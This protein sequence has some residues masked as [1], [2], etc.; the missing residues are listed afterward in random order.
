[1]KGKAPAFQ[2][3]PGDWVQDTRPLS[4]AAKGAWIDLLCI[5]WRSDT[6]GK[7]SL[8]LAGYARTFGVDEETAE[9]VINDLVDLGTC[10]TEPQNGSGRITLINRRMFRESDQRRGAAERQKRLRE[11]GGGSPERWTAIRVDILRRDDYM[12]AY[13]GKKATTVDHIIPK[14][15]GGSADEYSNL[16]SSCATCNAKKSNRTPEEAGLTFKYQADPRERPK[17]NAKVTPPS[18]SS[19]SSSPSKIKIYS[20]SGKPEAVRFYKTKKGKKLT[21]EKLESFDQFW[22]AFSYPRGKAE[23]AEVWHGMR[24]DDE[25]LAKIL[26]AAEAEAKNRQDIV[27]DGR[28]PKMAQ[29]WLSGRR[30]EDE[31]VAAANP[32]AELEARYGG[33]NGS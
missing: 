1:V 27:A 6:R 5:M 13:C 11:K 28:T 20:A 12:C 15:R 31:A 23:A 14:S 2:F 32:W 9:T 30:W 18:S 4:L 21:G 3:Y 33:E 24:L 25:Q 8:P 10:D 19:S 22:T 7:V 26:S 17:S 16:I 29:G